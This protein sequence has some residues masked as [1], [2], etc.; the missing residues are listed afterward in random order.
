MKPTL[1]TVAEVAS[2]LRCH[3]HTVR[4][5]IWSRKLSAVRVGDLVR[6]RE[7]DLERLAVPAA[8]GKRRV[9]RK[10]NGKGAHALAAVM[11]K[12][13]G[14]VKASEVKELERRIAEA[15]PPAEWSQLLD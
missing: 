2:R 12:L 6:V 14:K 9:R 11:R 5:W 13:R 4:R 8:A 3:P 1:L 7:E 15:D 10:G